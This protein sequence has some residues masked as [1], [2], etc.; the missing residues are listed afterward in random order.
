MVLRPGNNSYGET[1]LIPVTILIGRQA[2]DLNLS[3][4]V[5]IFVENFLYA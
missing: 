4:K 1:N 2:V 3:I 5:A